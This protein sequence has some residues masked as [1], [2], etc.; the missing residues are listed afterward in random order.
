MC[1][2]VLA[3]AGFFRINKVLHIKYGDVRFQ[4]GY[5]AIDITSSKMDQLRKGSEVFIASGSNVDTGPVNILRR[6][7]TEVGRYPIDSSH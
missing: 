6:Y 1:I 5:V 7:L 3:F 4:S 2:F